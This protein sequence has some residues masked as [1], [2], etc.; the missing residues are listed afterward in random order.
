MILENENFTIYEVEDLKNAFISEL[1]NE[2]VL[3]DMQNISKID[4]AAISL[5]LSLKKS[6]QL[7]KKEFSLKNCNDSILVSLSICGCDSFLGV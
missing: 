5:L 2:K 1:Q 4:M 3:I 6:A 7:Q